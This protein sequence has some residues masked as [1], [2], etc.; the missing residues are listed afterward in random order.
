MD[1]MYLLGHSF[2]LVPRVA[3]APWAM[4]GPL[5]GSA[6][7]RRRYDGPRQPRDRLSARPAATT[8]PACSRP[9]C[10]VSRSI[11]PDTDTAATTFPVPSMTGADT[12]ATPASRSPTLAAQPR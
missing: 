7:Q 1:L 4:A 12:D 5:P 6:D 10:R 2:G 11:G 9:G 3:S 8:S